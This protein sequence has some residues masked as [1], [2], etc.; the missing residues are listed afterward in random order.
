MANNGTTPSKIQ[1]SRISHVYYRYTANE[2]DAARQFM[3]DFGFFETKRAGPRTYYRGYSAEPFVL[4]LEESDKTEFGGAAFAVDSL[5]ELERARNVLP[6]E[7]KATE[8]YELKDAPG[9]GK[10][11]TFYEPVD[12]VPFHLVWGQQK[13]EPLSL[14]LPE[15]K[16]NLVSAPDY[17]LQQ[18]LGRT[19][20]TISAV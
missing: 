2:I 20:L 9:G 7:V 14:E 13:S 19:E 10:G 6:K 5:E 3:E 12:G 8:V 11:V 4:C 17:R 1:F 16:P 18:G 15:P